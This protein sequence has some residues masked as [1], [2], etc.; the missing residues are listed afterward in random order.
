MSQK[1][2]A[3][4][5]FG[6][7]AFKAALEAFRSGQLLIVTDDAARENEGDLILAAEYATADKIAFMIRFTSGILCAPLLRKR[8]Q[9]LRLP[10]M[11]QANEAPL[12]TAF[13]VSVDA[14]EG[15]T[16]GISAEERA[17]TLRKLADPRATAEDF[18]RPG[19]IFPL[20]AQEGGVLARPGHTEA[21]LDLCRLTGVQEVGVIGEIMNDDGTVKRGARLKEFAKRHRI[22]QI[23]VA[24][25]VNWRCRRAN[26][27]EGSLHGTRLC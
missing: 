27:G 4:S 12:G 20:I 23:G 25:L 11:I 1:K 10:L 26:S 9:E 6:S 3:D 2:R 22:H 7:V 13:T 8:A 14:K 15:L 21:A 16:T 5:P 18:V 17:L 19:H 24:D